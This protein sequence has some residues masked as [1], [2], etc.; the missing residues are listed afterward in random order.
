M[1]TQNTRQTF[2]AVFRDVI[3]PKIMEEVETTGIAKNAC[4]WL[5]NVCSPAMAF[6]FGLH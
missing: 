3:V 6:A 4:D 2:E 5:Q 1:A